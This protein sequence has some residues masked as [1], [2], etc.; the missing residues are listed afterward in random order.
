MKA[1]VAEELSGPSGLVYTD[2]D[3]IPDWVDGAVVIDVR[4]AGVCYPDLLVIRGELLAP[5]R[6]ARAIADFDAVLAA[7]PPAGL[8]QRALYGRDRRPAIRL[9]ACRVAR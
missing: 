8:A 7:A 5:G 1:V 2:V 4:A 3:D 6:C 9:G